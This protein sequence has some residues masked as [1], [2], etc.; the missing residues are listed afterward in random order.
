MPKDIT[1]GHWRVDLM[2]NEQA[3][4]NGLTS[5]LLVTKAEESPMHMLA[6]RNPLTIRLSPEVRLQVKQ[7]DV[8]DDK[9]ERWLYGYTAPQVK[10][11]L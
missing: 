10:P 11:F 6:V 5:I 9:L 1:I 8:P 7:L 3:L 4:H 2:P